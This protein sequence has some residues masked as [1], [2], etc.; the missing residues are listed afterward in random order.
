MKPFILFAMQRYEEDLKQQWMGEMKIPDFSRVSW[1]PLI[2]LELSVFD[3]GFVPS[4]MRQ[5]QHRGCDNCS[6]R[7]EGKRVVRALFHWC[8]FMNRLECTKL[9]FATTGKDSY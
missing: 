3:V 7:T 6:T 1:S 9:C 8:W 2:L 5:L 4:G